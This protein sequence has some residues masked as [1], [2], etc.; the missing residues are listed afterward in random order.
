ML[1]FQF[2]KENRY[3][4]LLASPIVPTTVMDV[5]EIESWQNSGI[6]T[7]IQLRSFYA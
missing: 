2:Y 7:A 1:G 6:P 4:H 5:N 3:C